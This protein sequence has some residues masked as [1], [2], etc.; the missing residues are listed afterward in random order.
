MVSV[1]EEHV[2]RTRGELNHA[3]TGCEELGH[4]YKLVRGLSAVLEERCTFQSR[5][6]I[7]PLEARRALFEEAANQVIATEDD[8][9]RVFSAVAFR[10]G[11]ST[12]DLDRS[13]YADLH[14]E[15]EL[16]IFASLPPSDLLKG[17]NF[18]HTLALL[19]HAKRLEVTYKGTDEEIEE[20]G[21]KLGKCS[22]NSSERASK[23]VAEW[24]PTRRIGYKASH[25]EALLTRLMSKKDWGLTAEVV[26]PLSSGKVNKFEISA[27]LEGRM[28]KPAQKAQEPLVKPRPRARLLNLPKG[29][30]IDVQ[31]TAARLGVTEA[32]VKR[33]FKE[34]GGGYVELGGILITEAK[35]RE[36]EEALSGA[37]DMRFKAV[38]GILRNLGCKNP[39]PV[40]E[41]L[42]YD[43]EWNRIRDE[44][45]VYRLGRKT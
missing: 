24:A 39:L 36:I 14:D 12:F 38:K 27:G 11:I 6:Q 21:G 32:E 18:A 10:M 3:L 15:Q 19:T 43:V 26:Y 13:L 42:G 22:V 41:A 8:R 16:A 2:G 30:I 9:K 35:R 20:L 45:L 37:T 25:L 34:G 44:S 29:E 7:D 23:I 33:R 28:I 17:Y 31:E 40:L 4:N 5:A 1:H